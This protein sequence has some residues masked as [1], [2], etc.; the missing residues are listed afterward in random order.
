LETIFKGETIPSKIIATKPPE[1][2]QSVLQL[3]G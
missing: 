2:K 3:P 1:I